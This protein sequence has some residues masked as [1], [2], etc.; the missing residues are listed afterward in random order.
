[1]K[2]GVIRV[3][4]ND[5]S[6]IINAHG[7]IISKLYGIECVNECIEDQPKGIYDESTE[8]E[9]IPKIIELAKK[10]ESSYKVDGIILSCAADPG[11]EQVR[12]AVSV[13]VVSAG[14]SVSHLAKSVSDKVG[15]LTIESGV[16]PS[17][18]S[19]LGES[20]VASVKP[21]GIENTSDLFKKNAVEQSLS[22]VNEL[23]NKGA[24]VIIFACTGYITIGFDK[25]LREK[26]G[27][28]V[29]SPVTAEGNALA[30]ILRGE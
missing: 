18:K 13:P 2:A 12:R 9:A 30:L 6:E 22:A 8:L 14:S 20:L 28:K 21:E 26:Y 16:P 29:I 4:T 23:I 25:L 3:L 7:D 17:M 24:E 5:S 11:L 1:M 19:V 10:M 27:V 15:V